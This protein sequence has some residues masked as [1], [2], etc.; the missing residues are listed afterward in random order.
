MWQHRCDVAATVPPA[1]TSVLHQNAQANQ[2]RATGAGARVGGLPLAKKS[3]GVVPCF[4]P[5]WVNEVVVKLVKVHGEIET[6]R[7]LASKNNKSRGQPGG[8]NR[9]VAVSQ[10][11]EDDLVGVKFAVWAGVLAQHALR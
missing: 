6:I 4:S 7:A 11:H 1:V 8:V 3:V 9:G 2:E 5:H 10:E